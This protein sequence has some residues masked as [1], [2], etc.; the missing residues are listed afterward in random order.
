MAFWAI[1]WLTTIEGGATR[2]P[3]AEYLIGVDENVRDQ[4]MAI[5]DG[6]RQTGPDQWGDPDSHKP[7]HEPVECCHEA[8]DK[9]G[10]TLHRLYLVWKR[11]EKLVVVVDGRSKAN[12]TVIEDAE[13]EKIA[14]LARGARDGDYTVAGADDFARLAFTKA[15]EAKKVQALQDQVQQLEALLDNATQP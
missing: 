15:Q 8:R 6:V 9:Q 14:A 3:A 13:Y 1:E 7:M 2:I 11:D 10:Q 5:V 12:N 4:L